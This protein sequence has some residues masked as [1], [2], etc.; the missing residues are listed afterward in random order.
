AVR[1]AKGPVE[2]G[3][4][5][6][7]RRVRVRATCSRGNGMPARA[8]EPLPERIGRLLHA[9]AEIA[10][11]VEEISISQQ[12]ATR[13]AHEGRPFSGKGEHCCYLWI[14]RRREVTQ[15]KCGEIGGLSGLEG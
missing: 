6:D 11:L 13:H 10:I 1:H 4:L 15:R 5:D 14:E 7:N 2:W 8:R 9:R 3:P 12:W